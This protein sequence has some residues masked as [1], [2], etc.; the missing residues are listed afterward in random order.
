MDISPFIK[1]HTHKLLRQ[2]VYDYLVCANVYTI[3]TDASKVK[4]LFQSYNEVFIKDGTM[5]WVE[6][7]LKYLPKNMIKR[8]SNVYVTIDL[9]DI[10]NRVG[11]K[12]I[13]TAEGELDIWIKQGFISAR[14]DT[15][16]HLLTFT[17]DQDIIDFYIPTVTNLKR[18]FDQLMNRMMEFQEELHQ[19]PTYLK[20]QVK[21][22]SSSIFGEEIPSFELMKE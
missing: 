8:L 6:M 1:F 15:S 10:L 9:K 5:K 7:T 13:E 19:H 21:S 3:E 4:Q 20:K 18:Q 2:M 16:C 14:L 12:D 11:W 17:E 22:T